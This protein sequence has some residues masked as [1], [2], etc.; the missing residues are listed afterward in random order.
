[1][2]S[3]GDLDIYRLLDGKKH[4][5]FLLNVD[6]HGHSKILSDNDAFDVKELYKLSAQFFELAVEINHGLLAPWQGDGGFAIFDTSQPYAYRNVWRAAADFLVHYQQQIL[7]NLLQKVDFTKHQQW[8]KKY[9]SFY[10]LIDCVDFVFDF[11]SPGHWCGYGLSSSLKTFKDKVRA[12]TLSI[13]KDAYAQFDKPHWAEVKLPVPDEKEHIYHTNSLGGDL[14][15]D[16][17]LIISNPHYREQIYK[18]QRNNIAARNKLTEFLI[19][20]GIKDGE[21]F[22]ATALHLL[23][24]MFIARE[25]ITKD[26]GFRASVWRRVGDRLIFA[27]GYPHPADFI[28]PTLHGDQGCFKRS[29]GCAG[30]V[31]QTGKPFLSSDLTKEEKVFL[32][33]HKDHKD[34]TGAF[35][36]ILSK[37]RFKI[38]KKY[39]HDEL[40]GVLC[41][42]VN[43]TSEFRFKPADA[44]IIETYVTPFL[45]NMALAFR[46][47]DDER[48]LRRTAR[49]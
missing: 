33:K 43:K 13:T 9:P 23:A 46:L 4:K 14:M 20:H 11:R 17:N 48:K 7:R 44:D 21:K 34:F 1:M 12:N 16:S 19:Q 27:A 28:T 45:L 47:M 30:K 2:L 37:E 32:R 5:F 31:W 35:F 40:L 26:D 22:L 18:H 36:P 49:D 42:G 10:A 3:Q 39:D 6:I 8:I 25:D 29:Q 38:E 24:N 41:L 15:S